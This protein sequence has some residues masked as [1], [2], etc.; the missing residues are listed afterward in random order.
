MS[1]QIRKNGLD[2]V[3]FTNASVFRSMESVSG[4]FNFVSTADEQN[5]LP[6]RENNRVE[7]VVDKQVVLTGFVE[8]IESN[9]AK[10]AHDFRATGRDVL[11]DLYDSAVG[12]VSEFTGSVQLI[13]ICR[14]VLDGI[15]LAEVVVFDETS[16]GI[17][18][19]STSLLPFDEWDIAS[20]EPGT[21]A[22]E[23][24]E[25]FA[26]K[27]QVLL[28]TDGQGNLILSRNNGIKLPVK[29][30]TGQDGNLKNARK[31][32]DN[33][34]RYRAYTAHS[35]LNPIRMVAGTKP[36][37]LVQQKGLAEDTEMRV[38][39][40]FTFNAEESSDS[41]TAKDRAIWEANFRRA[42]SLT[43]TGTVQGHSANGILW[44]PNRLVDVDD[45]FNDIKA[46]LL[47]RSVRY[48]SSIDLG[49][50]TT[51]DM[52]FLSA[53]TLQAEA[54]RRDALSEDFF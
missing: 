20:A 25:L 11:G 10:D 41:F 53:Y 38:S 9:A 39:R 30:K 24:L 15:N 14:A 43:Y 36:R 54:D 22:F 50:T 44:I 7:I 6:I 19:P 46:T 21:K 27:R 26:R 47:I 32:I 28:T 29:L 33:T 34:E 37:E 2:L 52:T 45:S 48:N 5:R 23:F 17:V 8:G 40:I 4:Y 42:R 49:N 1:L 13:D 16:I 35:Q 3:N 51:L 18:G 31:I 12:E